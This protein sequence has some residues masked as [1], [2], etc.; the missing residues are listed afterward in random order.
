MV[1]IY[2]I[3]DLYSRKI[4]RAMH[5]ENTSTQATRLLRCSALVEC[6]SERDIKLVLRVVTRRHAQKAR[7]R[8]GTA[9]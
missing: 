5:G 6:I 3:L 7:Q 2:L 9:P 1:L 8:A 4:E